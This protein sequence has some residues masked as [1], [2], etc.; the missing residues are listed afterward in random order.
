MRIMAFSS[1]SL[2]WINNTLNSNYTYIH[3][4]QDQLTGMI[5]TT[6]KQFLEQ[7]WHIY[8]DEVFTIDKQDTKDAY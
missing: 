7:A 5:C 6:E 8:T 4:K 3:I 2:C 1:G